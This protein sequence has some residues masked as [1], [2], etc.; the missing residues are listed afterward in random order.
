MVIQVFKAKIND[1]MLLQISKYKILQ[2]CRLTDLL[3]KPLRGV[4]R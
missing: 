1:F 2:S 3:V 4:K